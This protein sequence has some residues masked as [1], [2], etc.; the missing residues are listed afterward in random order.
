MFYVRIVAFLG[1]VLLFT[2]LLTGSK[3]QNGIRKHS[4]KKRDYKVA[5]VSH[6]QFRELLRSTSRHIRGIGDDIDIVVGEPFRGR[7]VGAFVYMNHELLQRNKQLIK[8]GVIVRNS[9]A[10]QRYG[11]P[12]I[13]DVKH[14]VVDTGGGKASLYHLT[15]LIAFRHS[16]SEGDIRGIL[17]TGTAHLNSGARYDLNYIPAYNRTR[18]S[19]T[20]RVNLLKDQF[21]KN[22]CK[23]ILR[24][25]K[26]ETGRNFGSR[27]AAQLSLND[28]ELF[29]DFLVNWK[30]DH[31]FKY[32][33][34]C[35]YSKDTK[36]VHHVTVVIVDV[37]LGK[38]LV[39]VD[40][41]NGL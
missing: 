4:L 8:N 15:H 9:Y 23:L 31:V 6:R 20:S 10:R 16:L 11:A 17:F 38:L 22:D 37:T 5:Y 26:V 33:V 29:F 1:L 34:E 41:L 24:Y 27:G 13:D 28:L 2:S 40:L 39:S 18:D 12:C 32:G 14:H 19:T 30:K 21:F 36:L 35:H 25:P 3:R 7:V